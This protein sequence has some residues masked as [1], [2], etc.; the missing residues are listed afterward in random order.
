MHERALRTY[1]KQ[2][3]AI[4]TRQAI[5]AAAAEKFAE[6]GFGGATI[7]DILQRAGCTKGAF[8]FHF[9]TKEQVAETLLDD[10]DLDELT[11]PQKNKIQEWVDVGMKSAHCLQHSQGFRAAM[12]LATGSTKDQFGSVW[13]EWARLVNRPLFEA[14]E[15]NELRDDVQPAEH[16]ESVML[17]LAGAAILGADGEGDELERVISNYYAHLLPS[18]AGPGKW[19]DLHPGRGRELHRTRHSNEADGAGSA[20]LRRIA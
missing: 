1:A 9:A 20:L 4:R 19:P 6:H 17:I 10:L 5:L 8:Y 11:A 12:R 7:A 2:D 14:K 3:R 15:R 13:D 18:I 16:S